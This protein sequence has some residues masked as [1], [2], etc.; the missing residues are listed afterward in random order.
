MYKSVRLLLILLAVCCLP[1]SEFVWGAEKETGNQKTHRTVKAGYFISP[2]FQ[3]YDSISHTYRGYGYDFILAVAQ[4]AGWTCEMV[5]L[6]YDEGLKQLADGRIDIMNDVE[7]TSEN[8]RRFIYSAVPSGETFICLVVRSD[9]SRIPYEGFSTFNGM[10]TGLVRGDVHN[11]DFFQYCREH[12]FAPEIIYYA[13][14]AEVAR[15]LERYEVEACIKD[16][17]RLQGERIVAEFAPRTYYFATAKKNTVLKKELDE[18]F[19]A[20]QSNDPSYRDKTYQKYYGSTDEHTL[21]LGNDEIAYIRNNPT[22]RVSYDPLWFPIS[23][24]NEQGEFDG[25]MLHVYE[26]LAEKTG[27]KFEFVASDTFE[28]S[29]DMFTSGATQMM[30]EFPYDFP[31]AAKKNARLTRPF[32]TITVVGAFN[33]GK[34]QGSIVALPPGYYQQFLTQKIRQEPYIFR[35]YPTIKNCLNALIA[36]N[37][38]YV[39]L[40]AYQLEYY[41]S[42][43]EY[44]NLSFKVMPDIGYRLAVAVSMSAD[45]HLY[46]IISRALTSIGTEQIDNIFKS[47]SLTSGSMSFKDYLF[48]NPETAILLFSIIIVVCAVTAFILAY[49]TALRKKNRELKTATEAKTMFLSN[50]SHDMRTPLN[51]VIGFTELAQETDSQDDVREYLRK[52]GTSGR[53]LQNL[54][55]DVL[56]ISKIESGKLTLEHACLHFPSLIDSITEPIRLNAESKKIGFTID[57]AACDFEYIYGDQLMLQKVILNILSNAVKYT[58]SGGKVVM[59]VNTVSVPGT[60]LNCRITVSDTGIGMSK[61]YMAHLFEPF[62][63]EKTSASYGVT[64]TGLGLSIIKKIVDLMGG[65]IEVQSTQ[66]QGSCFDIF[67]PFK[68]APVPEMN[69]ESSEAVPDISILKGKHILLCEDNAFNQEIGRTMLEHNGMS[70]VCASDGAEGI[71]AFS[72]SPAGAFDAVLMDL[73]MPNVDGYEAAMQIRKLDRIDAKTIPIIAMSADAYSDTVEKC[74]QNGMNGHVPKPVDCQALLAELIRNMHHR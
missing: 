61:E 28:G 72:L 3:E 26:K 63:R 36:G 67:L 37:V 45:T 12:H 25:A 16:S 21:I 41:R 59:T 48:T 46:S 53:F 9:N 27:L 6:T 15:A 47:V 8:S 51:A 10:K 23:F 65:K 60:V 68:R 34:T 69:A 31:W 74:L 1:L 40:N 54:I 7:V 70:V 52:I 49:S 17:L 56:D 64:G 38:D 73:R 19:T 11:E 66:G 4:C 18:A 35:N 43:A 33:P 13:T 29:M 57:T 24:R 58:P 50:M 22:V 44:H 32:T 62:M 14:N 30:A 39:F 5:P 20:L 55:N 2:N 71:K 42:K